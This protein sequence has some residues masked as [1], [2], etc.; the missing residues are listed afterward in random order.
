MNIK[1]N[2]RLIMA[3]KMINNITE[4]MQITGLSRNA[5]N[6]LWHNQDVE[7]VKLE[8][9]VQICESLKIKLS[10]LVEY[11]PETEK[12]EDKS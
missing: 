10:D 5:L 3:E 7:T 1:N 6:K 8:T 12:E 2:L 4:L 9:L 11:V